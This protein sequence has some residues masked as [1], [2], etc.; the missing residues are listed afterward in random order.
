MT[1]SAY[2]L[3]GHNNPPSFED[4]IT[5]GLKKNYHNELFLFEANLEKE[6]DLPSEINNDDD[7][8]RYS[9]FI[10][11]LA[12]TEKTLDAIRKTEKEV[13]SSKANVVHS[14]FKK[15]I[16][17]LFE[18]KG[19]VSE[20]LAAYLKKKEDEKRRA[21]EEK[22]RAAAEEAARKLK[23]A[24]ERERAAE[25]ARK[26]AEEEKRRIEAQAEE[27][28]KKAEAEAYEA[29]K[30]AEAETAAIKADAERQA[31]EAER[32][33]KQAAKEAEEKIKA[34]EKE[35][36]VLN[37]E[38]NRALDEAVR[39]DK[40][41]LKLER[42]TAAGCADFSRTRGDSSVGSISEYWIG[43]VENRESLD[44][45]ALREHIPFDALER[46]VQSYVDAGGRQLRGAIIT[47]EIKTV[48]R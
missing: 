2:A 24:Q 47:Q 36:K 43:S 29:Q 15:K 26:K 27:A 17:R 42:Q 13:Y 25:E 38:S 21:A 16:D 34:L 4:E 9:D 11:K 5:D 8:G 39:A 41:A 33:A 48:V 23:E 18:V 3:Y 37:R 35:V 32:L 44:L 10:K 40:T 22:A 46:A 6:K 1:N 31:K 19:R 12:S 45:E 7:A 30:K 20:P 14:F 28:R